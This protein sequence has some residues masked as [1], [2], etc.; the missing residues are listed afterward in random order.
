MTIILSQTLQQIKDP[1]LLLNERRVGKQVIVSF[2]NFTH[3][4]SR[5]KLLMGYIPKSK[6]LPYEW[7]NTPNI[8]VISI[9]SFQNFCKK[10]QF[11]IIEKKLFIGQSTVYNWLPFLALSCSKYGFF[12]INK[13][14][15]V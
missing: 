15:M 5:L 12:V 10:Y 2:P 14:K 9:K 4:S 1:I 6:H 3:L 11:N 8:R 7:Y 13:N